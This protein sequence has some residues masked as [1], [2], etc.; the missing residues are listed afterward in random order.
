MKKLCLFVI[1]LKNITKGKKMERI[2]ILGCGGHARSVADVIFRIDN[3]TKI[4]F[5]DDKAKKGEV[6]FNEWGG[7]N[8]YPLEKI[9]NAKDE[10][11]LFIAIGDNDK[12][13]EY[14]DRFNCIDTSINII[15]PESKMSFFSSLGV[16][17]F[18]ANMAYV[19]PEVHIGNYNIVNTSSVIEHEVQ[20]GNYTHISVN[21]TICGKC[22]IG[23]NVFLGAGAVVI[24]K[25]SICDN[26]VIGANSV[27]IDDISK[28]GVYVGNPA[29]YIRPYSQYV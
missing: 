8:V 4:T 28:P 25:I 21:S 29:K 17:N 3:D 19:G 24:D 15:S 7:Y 5:F 27:V 2:N 10:S 1:Q 16:G 22:Q 23:N 20:I 11:P 13:R 9:S 6:I 26:V 14:V 12:R 18:I